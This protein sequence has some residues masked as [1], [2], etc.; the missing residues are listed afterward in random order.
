MVTIEFEGHD[1]VV[2]L[3]GIDKLYAMRST[4]RV[5]LLHVTGVRAT[6]PEA[7]FDDIVEGGEATVTYSFR[8]LIIGSIETERGRTFYDVRDPAHTIA[9]DLEGEKVGH[10]V[11][12][13]AGETPQ[14]AVSRILAARDQS[15]TGRPPA[16]PGDFA[17]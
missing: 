10:F 4:L 11:V 17:E 9:I 6:P 2:R 14:H 15:A 12:E 13:V 8:R 3:Q 7:Q 1:L 16:A 5:P